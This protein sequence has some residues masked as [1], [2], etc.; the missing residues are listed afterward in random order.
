MNTF[1]SSVG[2]LR[3]YLDLMFKSRFDSSTQGEK[4]ALRLIED[5]ARLHRAAEAMAAALSNIIFD[6]DRDA[7]V[8]CLDD[9]TR[10]AVYAAALDAQLAD[11]D[12]IAEHREYVKAWQAD[13][14][15]MASASVTE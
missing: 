10:E 9:A 1:C 7:I 5:A 13:V 12:A 15:A 8:Y 3:H 2:P 11:Y 6:D 4:S 14:N